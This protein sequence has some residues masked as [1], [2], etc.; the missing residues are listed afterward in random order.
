MNL[1]AC[2]YI[3][4]SLIYTSSYPPLS[5]SLSTY[6][7]NL[8]LSINYYQFISIFINVLI[9]LSILLN[10]H[11][12]FST[13]SRIFTSSYILHHQVATPRVFTVHGVPLSVTGIAQV[14]SRNFHEAFIH[15]FQSIPSPSLLCLSI[16]SRNSIPIYSGF[17]S[18]NP[19]YIHAV[20]S[21]PDQIRQYSSYSWL[22]R[23]YE[24]TLSSLLEGKLVSL[25][26]GLGLL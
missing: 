2:L 10:I 20:L 15:H 23:D 25:L 16:Q 5:I 22:D 3:Y 14:R 7:P 12:L 19:H 26:K 9:Y 1:S 6:L 8:Y 13:C 18:S 17:S 21:R 4:I 11:T 24:T